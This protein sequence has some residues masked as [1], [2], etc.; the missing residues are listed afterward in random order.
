MNSRTLLYTA[1]AGFFLT[2]GDITLAVDAFPRIADR[3]FSALS[4]ENFQILCQRSDSD[5]TAPADHPSMLPS[6]LTAD[7]HTLIHS[8]RYVIATHDHADH[9]SARWTE[10]F[11]AAHPTAQ[12]IGAVSDDRAPKLI[13]TANHTLSILLHGERP[14]YYLPGITLEFLQLPHEG[15]E[16]AA[17]ANYGC[18]VTFTGRYGSKPCRVL[19]VG[20]AKPAD[21]AI[22]DWI[23]GRSIDLALLNFP[24]IA[25]PKGRRF[26]DEH[27]PG[28]EIAVLH[29]PYEQD[30]R[31]HYNQAAERAIR[32]WRPGHVTL[33]TDFGQT[34]LF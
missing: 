21:P 30:D 23:S 19:F 6:T 18:L 9:Y 31:N 8:V 3:G 12:F 29:L 2:E 1:N 26:L 24:W 11:L 16:F 34:V 20:D 14:T 7:F 28:T 4:Q 27:L 22:A 5:P 25:L 15:A 10:A 32:D 13:G 33:L 17:V